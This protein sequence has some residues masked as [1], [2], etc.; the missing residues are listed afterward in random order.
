MIRKAAA[1]SILLALFLFA[2]PV[3]ATDGGYGTTTTIP[4]CEYNPNHPF[5]QTTTTTT[6]VEETTT[7]APIVNTTTTVSIPFD[8]VPTTVPDVQVSSTVVTAASVIEVLPFTGMS[9]SMLAAA[10]S[11]F[12]L[13]GLAVSGLRRRDAD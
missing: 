4:R 7:T 11:L 12:L 2:V 5:C 10:S 13:A 3:S 8:S 1:L 6:E 9:S